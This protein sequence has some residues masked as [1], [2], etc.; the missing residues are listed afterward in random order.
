MKLRGECSHQ[1]DL[2]TVEAQ[3]EEDGKGE[4]ESCFVNRM[5]NYY[6]QSRQGGNE[7]NENNTKCKHISR[8]PVPFDK[9]G[10]LEE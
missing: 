8:F 3:Q 2:N 10:Y 5:F 7:N 1:L 6:Y 4:D 9:S